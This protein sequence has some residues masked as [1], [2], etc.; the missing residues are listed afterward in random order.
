[1]IRRTSRLILLVRY[2]QESRPKRRA[3]DPHSGI[4]SGNSFSFCFRVLSIS[5]QGRFPSR[6]L[7]LRFSRVVPSMISTGSITFPRLLDI[8]FPSLSLMIGCKNTVLKGSVSMSQQEN[9]TIRAT[10]KNRISHPVSRI[11]LGKNALRS[12]V[13]SLGHPRV[14]NG[15]RPEENHVSRTSL[16]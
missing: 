4:P 11:V 3:S 13:Y 16:S 2:I 14:E 7:D 5:S 8:F 12:N 1:M 10:Q 6:T 15:N 9:I